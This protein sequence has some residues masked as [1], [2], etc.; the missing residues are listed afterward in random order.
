MQIKYIQN[1]VTMV[2]RITLLFFF[3]NERLSNYSSF[4]FFLPTMITNLSL[5]R[6][7]NPSIL[8]T[9]S[10]NQW[11]SSTSSFSSTTLTPTTHIA[12][13][14][15]G[16]TSNVPP[17]LIPKVGRN[18]HLQKGHPLNTIKQIIESHFKSRNF[19]CFDDLLP[20]VTTKACFDDLLT[21]K[22]HISRSLSDTYYI[23]PQEDLVLRTHTSAHQNELMQAGHRS[24]LAT[25]DV[26]RRDEIDSSHYP[27]FHQMEG[28]H[29]FDPKELPGAPQSPESIQYVE[30]H[31]KETLE[32]V[33]GVLFPHCE[34]R[35]GNDSF[36]FTNPSFELEVWYNDE[37]LEVLGCGVVHKQI[38]SNC[39]LGHTDG[40]A[41]GLGLERLAMVLFNIP[42]I[43]L[44]WSE[45]VRFLSQF[46]ENELT[47]FKP[48]SKYPPCFKDVSFW[49]PSNFHENDLYEEIRNVA[50]DVVEDVTLID[51]FVHPKTNKKSHAYRITYRHMSRTL[52]DTE[53]DEMQAQVRVALGTELSCEVR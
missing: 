12:G 8:S 35:W 16:E 14:P 10:F 6:K 41:F 11:C 30:A 7:T 21:P 42:D 9:L 34:T 52:T 51:E 31:L 37:W 38:L 28:V 23:D 49:L 44:F 4:L 17:T 32:G 39:D 20:V 5:L 2:T 19:A 13:V 43:R 29:I 26:Y 40:W 50:G 18:L 33:I 1:E 24:F 25:G 46:S 53:V 48:F 45:D 22:D 36:P 3:S 15:L 27:C 47:T